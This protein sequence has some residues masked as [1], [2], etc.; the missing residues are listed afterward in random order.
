MCRAY[1][2]IRISCDESLHS[3]ERQRKV[4]SDRVTLQILNQV[5]LPT[6]KRAGRPI[7]DRVSYYSFRGT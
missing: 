4:P 2:A 1:D 5:G 7:N 3:D 6:I